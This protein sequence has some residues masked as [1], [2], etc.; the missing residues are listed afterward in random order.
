LSE[1][2]ELLKKIRQ[3]MVDHELPFFEDI[4]ERITLTETHVLREIAQSNWYE[5][6]KGYMESRKQ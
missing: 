2:E 1:R 3:Q 4:W 6:V 5:D